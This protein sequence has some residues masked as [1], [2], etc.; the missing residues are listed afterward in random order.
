MELPP[1]RFPT[2]QGLIIHTWERTWQYIKKAGTVILG[3][4]ILLWAM[5][6]FPYLSP[7]ESLSLIS[8]GSQSTLKTRLIRKM[9]LNSSRSLMMRRLR[10]P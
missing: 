3:I 6:S 10:K 9:P 5:M 1:Y 4:S 2:L 7:T 8:S